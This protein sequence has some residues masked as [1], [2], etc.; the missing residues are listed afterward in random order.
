[1]NDHPVVKLSTRKVTRN[2]QAIDRLRRMLEMAESGEL[3][4]L[5]AVFTLSDGGIGHHYSG[6]GD[7]I[8]HLGMAANLQNLIQQRINCED[9]V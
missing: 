3:I 7:L 8:L 6:S 9:E 2:Q 4:E 5:T 1:M